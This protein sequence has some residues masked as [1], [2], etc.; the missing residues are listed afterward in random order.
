MLDILPRE[1]LAAI[2]KQFFYNEEKYW[3]EILDQSRP[4]YVNSITNYFA[5]NGNFHILSWLQ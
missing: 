4:F 2:F 5:T 1:L 3:H